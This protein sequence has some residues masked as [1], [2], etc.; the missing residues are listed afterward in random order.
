MNMLET[1][2]NLLN[3]SG[4]VSFFAD[5]GWICPTIRAISTGA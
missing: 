5:G 4:F 1:L 2:Q 3:D